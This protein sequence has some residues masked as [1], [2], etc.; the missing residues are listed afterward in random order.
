M[1]PNVKR[2]CFCVSGLF[3]D[4]V[5]RGDILGSSAEL[6]LFFLTPAQW[7]VCLNSASECLTT[8]CGPHNP[9][10]GF[11]LLHTPLPA[12]LYG[13]LSVQ[14]LRTRSSF[15]DIPFTV[16]F[17]LMLNFKDVPTPVS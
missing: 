12:V 1:C 2:E 5:S 16:K 15:L 6:I 8:S 13:G 11:I 17:N 7:G 3:G 14:P 9:H 4:H 10:P